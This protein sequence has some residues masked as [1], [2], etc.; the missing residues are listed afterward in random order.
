MDF[1]SLMPFGGSRVQGAGQPA[2]P[3][4]A[5]RREMDRMF[6]TFA[7]AG[8]FPNLPAAFSSSN[9]YLT[10][11]VN[12]SETEAGLEVSAELPGIDE[13]NIDVSLDD[14]V[15]TLRAEHT[16]EKEE[17]D[18]AKHYHLVERSYG[19]F[20]RRIALPFEPDADKIA[21][22][23]DKGV[24]KIVVPR[25]AKAVEKVRKIAVKAT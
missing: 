19:T 20:L 8:A 7:Q 17:K 11:K 16:A 25:S 13:K 18:E 14:N 24:L 3:F 23:F 4:Q 9:G 15:L 22:S 2:D 6:D 1:R 21:A 5:M 10:P 12:V